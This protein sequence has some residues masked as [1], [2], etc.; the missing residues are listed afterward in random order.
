MSALRPF[1]RLWLRHPFRLALGIALA[2]VT[3]LASI[4]LLTLSGWFLAASS[5]A[6]VAGLYTFNYMLPAAGVR[7]AAIIRTAARYAE[8]LVSHDATFRVLQHL[9]V[10]TFSRLMALSPGQLSQ[11]RQADLLNRFVADVD[12]LDHLYLRVISPLL[13]A[14]VV[15]VV[16]IFGI[17]F[18]DVP[19]AL[20]LG[21]IMLSTLIL[22]PLLFYRLG[23]PAGIAIAHGRARWRL[24]LMQWLAAQAELTLYGA[25]QSW[26]QQL[27]EDEQRWQQAQSKQQRL[28]AAAQSL[29]LLISGITVT[30]L[31]WLCAATISEQQLPGSLIALVVF[32]ALAA[33]EALAPV[34][35]AFLPMSQ[36]TTAA[37]RVNDIID[38]APAI[39]FPVRSDARSGPLYVNIDRLDFSYPDRPDK[40]LNSCTL[41]VAAGEHIALL[42]P[43]GCGKSTLLALLTRAR[44]S[45]H[46]VISL[47]DLPITA[48]SE[49]ALR[50]RISVVT[51]RV[52]LFSQSLRNNLL[53]ACPNATDEQ[54]C[55]VLNDV[56]LQRLLENQEGLNAWMGEGGRPLSGGELRRLA[57]A[58]ALLHDGDLWLLDEPTEGLDATTEQHILALLQR[59]TAGKTMIMVTHRLSGLEQMDR[60]CVMDNGAIVEQGSHAEL[61]SK[62]GRYW[63]FRQRIAL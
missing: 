25:S 12:T 5:V 6:G 30:L 58:R 1:L 40:V 42:G 2:I 15:I 35:G 57:L 26:R 34:A 52:H 33:F 55:R 9:R 53:L 46:G 29:L 60:I 54:L 59:L 21:G 31:L 10:H 56:G 11:F 8:R 18:I 19:L 27:D 20:T 49:A 51:Q 22:M 47:N 48:W 39:T 50:Q 7:G 37:Q 62:A 4:S 41:Q 36:V 14:F 3:L 61:I 45:Q 17:S 16:V 43:T 28:Q 38:Q 32:C 13:G 63:R 23:S 44:E 24:Q